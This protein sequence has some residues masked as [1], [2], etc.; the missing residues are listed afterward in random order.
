MV[1]SIG[2]MPQLPMNLPR[3]LMTVMFFG[4]RDNSIGKSIS[5]YVIDRLT[6]KIEITND[7]F[8]NNM[9][10]FVIPLIILFLTESVCLNINRIFCW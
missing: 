5:D 7:M 4:W 6:D 1:Y 8:F 9:I 3:E 2:N 10:S